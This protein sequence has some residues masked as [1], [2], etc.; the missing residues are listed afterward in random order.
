MTRR[1]IN[2]VL[3]VVLIA[4]PAAAQ[5]PTP[6]TLNSLFNLCTAPELN[7]GRVDLFCGCWREGLVDRVFLSDLPQVVTR[8]ER[9][10]RQ[11]KKLGAAMLA[12]PQLMTLGEDCRRQ[13]GLLPL[14]AAPEV[15]MP[16]PWERERPPVAQGLPLPP[17]PRPD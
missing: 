15:I 12:V 9:Q 3:A 8:L 4:A 11:G 13:A 17:V 6:D 2:A 1:D 14:I 5:L 16:R 10:R 7:G